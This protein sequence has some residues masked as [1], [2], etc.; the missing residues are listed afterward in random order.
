MR[1]VVHLPDH[2][3][4][5]LLAIVDAQQANQPWQH[6]GHAKCLVVDGVTF[7]CDGSERSS[8][9]A[10]KIAGIVAVIVGVGIALELDGTRATS[11]AAVATLLTV[12]G[13]FAFVRGRRLKQRG[14]ALPRRTGCYL[15]E[16]GMARLGI[17][18]RYWYPLERILRFETEETGEHRQ[19]RI[20]YRDVDGRETYDGVSGALKAVGILTEW[21]E[22]VRP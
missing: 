21:L 19:V 22:R 4:A 7:I 6:K 8:G 1:P 16:D 12:G 5:A 2:A 10:Y 18:G 13:A 17:D 9:G 15:F 11:T 3:E 20:Y 14:E